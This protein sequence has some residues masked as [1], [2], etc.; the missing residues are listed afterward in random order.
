MNFKSLKKFLN[1]KIILL[2]LVI[3]TEVYDE[4]V[5]YFVKIVGLTDFD[6]TRIQILH[7]WI[8]KILIIILI[9]CSAFIVGA[10][11]IKVTLDELFRLLR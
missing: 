3:T 7:V 5:I 10:N 1:D 11:C 6:L 9:L 2:L 8:L 4:I